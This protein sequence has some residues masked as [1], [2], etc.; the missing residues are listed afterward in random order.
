MCIS[1]QMFQDFF[2]TNQT[3]DESLN[4]SQVISVEGRMYPVSVF[5]SKV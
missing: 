1:I 2:E 4:T 5:Y 3:S